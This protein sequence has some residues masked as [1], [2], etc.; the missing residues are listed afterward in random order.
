MYDDATIE[1]DGRTFQLARVTF[2]YGVTAM[3]VSIDQD[4]IGELGKIGLLDFLPDSLEVAEP[5]QPKGNRVCVEF[6]AV[7][8]RGPKVHVAIDRRA[9]LDWW[10]ANASSITDAILDAKHDCVEPDEVRVRKL[11]KAIRFAEM[12]VEGLFGW[13]RVPR[14]KAEFQTFLKLWHLQGWV[15][16]KQAFDYREAA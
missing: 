6:L 13:P 12:T 4:F 15:K 5:E 11:N 7:D 14:L 2:H 9:V 1:I 8:H 3:S 10:T 16:S